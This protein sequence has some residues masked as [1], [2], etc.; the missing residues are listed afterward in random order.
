[1]ELGWHHVRCLEVEVQPLSPDIVD[2]N[3][4]P[5]SCRDRGKNLKGDKVVDE[6]RAVVVTNKRRQARCGVTV[7]I[8]GRPESP[9]VEK[10]A[11]HLLI[12]CRESAKCEG[13]NSRPTFWGLL[14]S[15]HLRARPA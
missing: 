2:A 7:P 15:T 13:L 9:M 5:F 4:I 8:F 3:P 1:M 12:F 14:G 6:S 11:E 10:Y